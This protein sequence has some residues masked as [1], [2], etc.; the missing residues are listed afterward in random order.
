MR[1]AAS[2]SSACQ[3]HAHTRVHTTAPATA[4]GVGCGWAGGACSSTAAAACSAAFVWTSPSRVFPTPV[5]DTSATDRRGDGT[6]AVGSCVCPSAAVSPCNTTASAAALWGAVGAVTSPGALGSGEAAGSR[7]WL[8]LVATSVRVP[9]C[10]RAGA[11]LLALGTPAAGSEPATPL[12]GAD[13]LLMIGAY[14]CLASYL[15][16]VAVAHGRAAWLADAGQLGARAHRL[17]R[18]REKSGSKPPLTV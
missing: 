14:V 17:P 8:E 2:C 10:E 9:S 4:D 3:E 12:S 7:P 18:G 6:G 5:T 13:A 1:C 16:P 11:A 15:V